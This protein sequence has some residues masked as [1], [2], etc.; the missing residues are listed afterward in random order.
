MASILLE[1]GDPCLNTMLQAARFETG[2]HPECSRFSGKAKDLL[3]NTLWARNR[4]RVPHFWPLLPEVGILQALTRCKTASHS[5]RHLRHMHIK[6][7][8][9]QQR[10]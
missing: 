2:G 1:S 4:G 5:L 8:L 7:S 10:R 3:A 9:G 6:P